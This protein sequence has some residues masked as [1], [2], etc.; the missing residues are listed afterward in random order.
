MRDLAER[1]GGEPVAGE[2]PTGA[3][4]AA[5]T[6]AEAPDDDTPIVSRLAG[7]AR[8]ARIVSRFVAELPERLERMDAA[9]AAG[10]MVELASLAHWLKGSGGS[11][12]FD[13]LYEPSLALEQA[14]KTGE[15]KIA[16]ETLAELH[17][18]ERRI[19]RGV[20]APTNEVAEAEA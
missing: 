10:D 19:Q 16:G 9:A 6:P 20:A 1:L 8:L 14:A 7:H 12:G 5:A 17:R 18:L 15:A 3:T 13:Q 2:P 11:M 4:A